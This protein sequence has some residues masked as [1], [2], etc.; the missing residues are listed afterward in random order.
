MAIAEGDALSD[1]V[2][3]KIGQT[4]SGHNLYVAARCLKYAEPGAWHITEEFLRDVDPRIVKRDG[5]FVVF[6][7]GEAYEL[8]QKCSTAPAM[9][10]ARIL[11]KKGE[12]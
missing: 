1:V 2:W 7:T 4:T 8:V 5:P 6:A 10:D 11:D 9:W 12:V 3:N